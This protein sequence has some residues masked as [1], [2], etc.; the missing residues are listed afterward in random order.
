MCRRGHDAPF[1]STAALAPGRGDVALPKCND[2]SNEVVDDVDDALDLAR[3][4]TKPWAEAPATATAVLSVADP[5]KD[6][7]RLFKRTGRARKTSR[8]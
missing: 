5:A 1:F 8:G 2:A 4:K 6:K 3:L 7:V